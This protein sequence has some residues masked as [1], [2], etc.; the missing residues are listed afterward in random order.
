MN[1]DMEKK[2]DQLLADMPKREYDLDAWLTEDETAEFDRIVSE[3]HIPSGFDAGSDGKTIGSKH[4]TLWRWVAAA[5]CFLLIIGVGLHYHFEEPVVTSDV[6]LGN[7]ARYLKQQAP[8]P[9]VTSE[10]TPEPTPKPS[11][12]QTDSGHTIAAPVRT[13]RTESPLPPRSEHPL[14]STIAEERHRSVPGTG[15]HRRVH[16]EAGRIQQ[17]E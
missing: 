5:A 15:S 9:K 10:P 7:T 1:E 14:R 2:L 16:C 3:Q 8:L 12:P 4:R 6:T 17:G 11:T 13:P